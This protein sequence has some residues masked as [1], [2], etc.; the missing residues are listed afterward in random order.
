VRIDVT[1]YVRVIDRTHRATPLGMGFGRTRFSSPTGAFK[2]LYLAQDTC[3]AIAERIVRDRFQG[4]ARRELFAHELRGYSVFAVNNPDLLSLIDLRHEGASLLGAPTDAVRGRAHQ[5]G[6]TLSQQLYDQTSADGIVYMSRITNRECVAVYD[7]AVAE[8]LVVNAPVTA[9]IR[10]ASLP[11]DLRALHIEVLKDDD[12]DSRSCSAARLTKHLCIPIQ[13][14]EA[15]S[16][17]RRLLWMRRNPGLQP[18]ERRR[19][20]K[21]REWWRLIWPHRETKTAREPLQIAS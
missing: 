10:L 8:K 2:A 19:F 13:L 12:R 5:A 18:A 1:D 20:Q 6:R 17:V 14:A 11:T 16:P 4:R 9:L 21:V 7:R 15:V 3:T